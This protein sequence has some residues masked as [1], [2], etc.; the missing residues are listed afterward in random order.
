MWPH[1]YMF[2]VSSLHLPLPALPSSLRSSE[3]LISNSYP[4]FLPSHRYAH[5]TLQFNTTSRTTL[6][7]LAL[8]SLPTPDHLQRNVSV[9]PSMSSSTCCSFGSYVLP[10]VSGLPLC[11]WCRK[12]QPEIGVHVYRALNHITVPDCYPVSY[13]HDFSSSLQGTTTFSKHDLVHAYHQIPVE[14]LDVHKTAVT[15]PFGLYEFVRMPFG[16]HNAAQT[17]QHFMDEVLRGLQFC[18]AYMDDVLIASAT[19]EEHLEHL[20]L[21]F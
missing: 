12:R 4:N 8:Q 2:R 11:T 20:R 16:L 10:P 15:T 19:P 5:L 3:I 7:P 6:K 18:Y 9:W 13:I 21:V 1:T 17:F 14:P